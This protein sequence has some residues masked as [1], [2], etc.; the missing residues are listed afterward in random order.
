MYVEFFAKGL[1]IGLAIA[2]P[3]GPVGV[4]CVIRSVMEGITEGFVSALG[5]AT[6]DAAGAT[7]ALLGLSLI[8]GF[9]ASQQVWFRLAGG[10]FLCYL[11]FRTFLSQPPDHGPSRKG[12]GLVGYYLTTFLI[13]FANPVTIPSFLAIF[14]AF[15]LAG[16]SE[17]AGYATALISGVFTG[18][19]SWW[20]VLNGG[21]FMFPGEF[22][23]TGYKWFSR[24]AGLLIIAFG[25]VVLV[26]I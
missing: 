4:L 22:S 19:V 13:T 16:A 15:G 24:I 7:A 17:K 25:F 2:V 9:L 8:S 1:L 3:V 26:G 5:V 12:N 6:A 21:L 20:L 11:G 18:S 10:I 23:A 14:A